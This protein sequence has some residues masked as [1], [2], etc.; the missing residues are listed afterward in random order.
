MTTFPRG[1]AY[2]PDGDNFRD[3]TPTAIPRPRVS[4][5]RH[6]LAW[7]CAV[8]VTAWVFALAACV[9]EYAAKAVSVVMAQ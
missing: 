2:D 8:V 1:Y 9:A 3:P 4:I 7:G 6:V 5:F